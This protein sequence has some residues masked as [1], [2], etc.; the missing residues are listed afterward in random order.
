MPLLGISLLDFCCTGIACLVASSY[1]ILQEEAAVA[2]L[3]TV[4]YLNRLAN[5]LLAFPAAHAAP[6][7][8]WQVDE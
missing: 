4:A 2:E 5:E 8:H 7:K 6:S 1:L 3:R